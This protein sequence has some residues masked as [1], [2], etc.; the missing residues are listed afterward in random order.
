MEKHILSLIKENNRVIIPNFGAF[1][2]AK[3]NGFTILFNN[4]LSFNDGL[5]IDYVASNE[6]ITSE[7]AS[8]KVDKYVE[9]VKQKLD[10]SGEY[11]I[12]GLGTFTKDATGILR[13]TQAEEVNG[14]EDLKEENELLDIDGFVKEDVKEEESVEDSVET[15]GITMVNEDPLVEVE[16][17]KVEEKFEEPKLVEESKTSVTNVTNQYI[18]ED[19]KRRNRSIL[20]FLIIFV[21]LPIIG[22][23]VYFSFFN[24]DKTPVKKEVKTQPVE[25]PK[26]EDSIK[27]DDK[28]QG[29]VVA[30]PEVKKEEKPVVVQPVAIDKPHHIIVGSFKSNENALRYIKSL[31]AKGFDKCTTI[32]HNSMTLVSIESFDKV[33]K[34][35]QRQEEILNSNRIE[36][37][38]LTKRQ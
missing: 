22:V 38:I 2:V 11:I 26:T 34:A 4:F 29:N 24:N 35:Q 3:E 32:Q 8:E 36:S 7:Q 14:E 31:E 10:S 33:Y 25:K 13:F 5:L 16:E 30:G 19:K 28:L 37:W 20:I 1:I 12:N 6:G 18:E 21:L 27:L 23:I 17:E 15:P 9:E